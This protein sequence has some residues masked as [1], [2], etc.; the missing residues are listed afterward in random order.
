MT[1]A[2]TS[3]LLLDALS[4]TVTLSAGNAFAIFRFGI[5][6]L[7]LLRAGHLR[8]SFITRRNRNGKRLGGGSA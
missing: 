6:A 5:E 7:V 2:V 1:H 3:A 4:L 8:E